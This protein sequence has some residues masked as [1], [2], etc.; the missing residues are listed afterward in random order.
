MQREDTDAAF[1]KRL[2]D[3]EEIA[4][5]KARQAKMALE[6]EDYKLCRQLSDRDGAKGA[7]R[8]EEEE[9]SPEFLN[10]PSIAEA[11]LRPRH[12]PHNHNINF[13]SPQDFKF[14]QGSRK[15]PPQH[16]ILDYV[17]ESDTDSDS[18]EGTHEAIKHYFRFSS[19]NN[20]C[21]VFD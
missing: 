19:L 20:I 12:L 3:E 14:T 16:I 11:K 10:S 13:Q 2:F 8:E 21:T 6:E 18:E 9:K 1:A 5:E 4:L 15:S 7:A 17:S